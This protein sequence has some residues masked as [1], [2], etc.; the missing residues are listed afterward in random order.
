M[1]S[2]YS[3]PLPRALFW[4]SLQLCTCEYLCI[5]PSVDVSGRAPGDLGSWR[6]LGQEQQLSSLAGACRSQ[7]LPFLLPSVPENLR[8]LT[9]A[10][11]RCTCSNHLMICSTL[12]KRLFAPP[13]WSAWST[14]KML[15]HCGGSAFQPSF[16]ASG[17]C[18]QKVFLPLPSEGLPP[19]FLLLTLYTQ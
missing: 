10:P 14:S 13:K 3:S 12:L 2:H 8:R 19:S 16:F 18:P 11:A 9:P 15:N 7:K 6:T 1:E 5:P 17:A 4:W